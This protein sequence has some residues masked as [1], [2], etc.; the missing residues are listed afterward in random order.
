MGLFTKDPVK[1]E[2]KK[3]QKQE[4]K[5]LEK[6]MDKKDSLLNQFLEDKVPEAMQS[7]LEAAFAKAFQL[8]FNKG[9][10]VIEKTYNKEKYK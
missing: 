6:R 5:F 9:T 1:A 2:M 3:L 7:K 4:D 10:G 8:V